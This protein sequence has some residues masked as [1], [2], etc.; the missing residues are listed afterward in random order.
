MNLS[1]PSYVAGPFFLIIL[2]ALCVFL[3]VGIKTVVNA[4]RTQFKKPEPEKEQKPAPPKRGRPRTG[5]PKKL[6]SIEIDPE[7]VDR[8]YVRKTG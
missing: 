8:I 6:R 3:V 2:F 1:I 5:K 7:Q 4:V